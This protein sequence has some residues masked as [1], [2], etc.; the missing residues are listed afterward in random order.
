MKLNV[1]IKKI[2][3]LAYG[4]VFLWAVVCLVFFLFY[5]HYHFFYQEQNQ[6]FL[7]SWD[8]VETYL[9]H[10]GWLANL[11]GD[12]LTQFYYYLYAGPIILTGALLTLG[13]LT[14]RFLQQ[15]HLKYWSFLVAILL[16]TVFVVFSF[17]YDYHLSNI[18]SA[19][20]LMG[21]FWLVALL[22]RHVKNIFVKSIVAV[23]IIGTT[24]WLFGIPKMGKFSLP[25]FYLEK[26][27][28]VDNE[29]YFGNYE[30]VIEMVEN[31]DNPTPEMLFF[32]NLVQAKRHNLPNVLLKYIPN[33]LGT[34]YRIGPKSPML[35][36]KNMNELYWELGDM[37]FTERAAM[38]GNV[39]SENNRNVRMIKRLAEVNLVSG[40][41]L[42]MNKYMRILNNT[43]VY[44]KQAERMKHDE[45]LLSKRQFVNRQD[46]MQVSDNLHMIMM[47]LLDSNPN[48]AIA[49]QYMLC[50]D[51]LLKDIKNF[52]RDYDRYCMDTGNEQ[53][54]KL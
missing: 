30:R 16:M 39:F 19:I 40:D 7:L 17:R 22:F 36:I 1:N 50:S 4:A 46:T 41:T 20:G 52:K 33:D 42:A 49:L 13:D 26:Q 53:Q 44:A 32:Y 8:Y 12:F 54:E 25:N 28:A 2:D 6:L 37:T 24:Y 43:W 15:C 29:Y 3:I 48:N 27:F 5:Y 38:M 51:L 31:D 45:R 47:E 23:L 9:P 21:A 34:F 14:R 35:T 10:V 18:I 11:I